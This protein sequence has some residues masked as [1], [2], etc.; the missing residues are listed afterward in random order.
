LTAIGPATEAP[1]A[2]APAP[3]AHAPAPAPAA[4]AA[5]K[6]CSTPYFFDAQ[7]NKVFKPDCL[8]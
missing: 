3:P 8:K 7:G 1:A 6:D 4:A 5:A 2:A